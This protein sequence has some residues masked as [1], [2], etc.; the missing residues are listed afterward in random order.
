[1]SKEMNQKY[2]IVYNLKNK[3]RFEMSAILNQEVQIEENR[4]IDSLKV[5][6]GI[7]KNL[8]NSHKK[9]CIDGCDYKATIINWKEF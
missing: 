4:Q 3:S 6:R 9:Q 5:I 8:E 2:F 1:M 7:E